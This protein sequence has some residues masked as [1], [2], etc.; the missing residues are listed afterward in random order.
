ME[1]LLPFV[2][3]DEIQRKLLLEEWVL[4]IHLWLPI[5]PSTL[6]QSNF[7]VGT[8][9]CNVKEDSAKIKIKIKIISSLP[10][11][12]VSLECSGSKTFSFC[13]LIMK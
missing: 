1:G 7:S 13:S 2:E 8:K 6:L 11:V 9:V 4:L 10:L 3:G 5:L 12:G